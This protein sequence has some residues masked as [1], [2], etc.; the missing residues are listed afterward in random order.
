MHL[1]KKVELFSL[2][3]KEFILDRFETSTSKIGSR[4]HESSPP[5]EYLVMHNA[6]NTTTLHN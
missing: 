2:A 5:L 6:I 1:Y 3:N 4:I